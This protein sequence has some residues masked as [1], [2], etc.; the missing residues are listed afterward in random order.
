M[1]VSSINRQFL[2]NQFYEQDVAPSNSTLSRAVT[3]ITN[4]QH[5]QHVHT[6]GLR[7]D[8]VGK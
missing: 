2:G 5:E 7:G 4:S 1:K 3:L 8:E 6:K